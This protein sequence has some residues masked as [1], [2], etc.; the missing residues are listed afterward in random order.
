MT[1]GDGR[2]LRIGLSAR[3][4]HE[5]PRELNFPGKTLQYLE[6]SIAHW[7][8]AHGALAFMVPT[9]EAGGGVQRRS[10]SVSSYVQELDALILQGGA[11]MAPESYGMAP[12]RADWHGDRVRD[13]YEIELFWEFVIQGKPV[14]GICR[15]HQLINVALGGTLVQDIATQ[16]PQAARHVE[17]VLYDAHQHEVV[18]IPDTRLAEIYPGRFHGRVISIHHQAIDRLGN[19]LLVE[20]QSGDGIIEAIRWKGAGYVAGFQ[21]HPEFHRD[22]P[23]LLDSGPIMLDF[24]AAARQARARGG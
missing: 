24:L 11:D 22:S 8:M 23:D 2:P 16:R 1:P 17:P 4:M 12:L 15:G 18:L 21:W 9:I 5:P 7:V 6:Q 3:L 13:R 20:A 19:D 14:L 10:I